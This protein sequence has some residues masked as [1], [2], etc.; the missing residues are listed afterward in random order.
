MRDP[1]DVEAR[2]V[3]TQARTSAG[4]NA[5]QNDVAG[6]VGEV[7]RQRRDAVGDQLGRRVVAGVGD[8][9]VQVHERAEAQPGDPAGG[10]ERDPAEVLAAEA[11]QRGAEQ[12]DAAPA[13]HL[14]RRPR[15]LAEEQVRG[16]RGDGADHEP[17]RAAERVARDQHDVGRRLDVGQRGER[18]APE[19][20]HRGERRHECDHARRRVRALVPDEADE[21]DRAEDEER[22][23]RSS[24]CEASGLWASARSQRGAL[25]G[26][27]AP[28]APPSTRATWVAKY[29]PPA[30]TSCGVASAT[31]RAVAE[32]DHAGRRT[33]PRTRRRGWRRAPRCAASAARRWRGRARR[34][35]IPRV[36]SSSSS[37]LG[38]SSRRST[39]ASAERCRSPPDTSRG[40]RSAARARRRAGVAPIVSCIRWSPGFCKSSATR[41]ARIVPAGRLDQPGD[42]LEERRLARPVAPHQRDR[43]AGRRAG[44]TP[45]STAA[46]SRARPTR[47]RRERRLPP[48][49]GVGAGAPARLRRAGVRASVRG[50]RRA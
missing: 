36:G 1:D 48:L 17:G 46:P 22:G 5:R 2:A 47:P 30:S 7:E 29:Q 33:R 50:A 19:R 16:E 6:G 25:L 15:A 10:G 4:P 49:R 34:G 9:H 41:P 24:S 40:W 3:A 27:S 11:G 23:Q 43:L 42:R 12:A 26:V 14:P 35:S 45:R 8:P 28:P 37:D 44:S 21:R 20:G 31:G 38:G 32:Q 39:I 13:D 18:D